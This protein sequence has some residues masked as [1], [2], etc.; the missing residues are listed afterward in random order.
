[1]KDMILATLLEPHQLPETI[2]NLAVGDLRLDSRLI[3]SGDVFICL[4]GDDFIEAAIRAGAHAILCHAQASDTRQA[5]FSITYRGAIPQTVPIIYVPDLAQQLQTLAQLRY[6][7]SCTFPPIVGVTGTNGKSTLV[8][9]VAQLLLAAKSHNQVATIG[10]LGVGVYGEKPFLTGM[11]TP[12]ILTNYKAMASFKETQVSVVTMEVSSHGLDQQRVA[13]LPIKTAIFTNL[14]QD[15]LDY[16]KTLEAYAEA[17]KRLFAMP[18]VTT[19]IINADDP[20]AQTMLTDV[21]HAHVLFY[22]LKNDQKCVNT[23]SVMAENIQAS[24]TGTSFDVVSPW[25]SAT[26]HS[27]FYGEFNVYNCLAAICAAVVE[28][29]DFKR[30]VAAIIHLEPVLGRMQP[31]AMSEQIQVVIDYAHTP[32]ALKQTLLALRAHATGRLWVVFGCGGDRDKR[33]RAQM[34]A[35]AQE[36]ADEIVLTSDN[37]RS[38]DPNSILADIA[39][40]CERE[41]HI[42]ADR[43][44]AI[45]YALGHAQ[46]SD[47][48]L[49]AGK[50]HEQFQIIGNIKKPFSDAD[51]ATRIL[52]SLGR[53]KNMEDNKA[54]VNKKVGAL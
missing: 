18:S 46:V 23:N 30:V 32:D 4:G 31:L 22:G 9:L 38:E 10:T 40:G 5:K 6:G 26:V 1:M 49:I 7:R 37:P 25:G 28:G 36:L 27:P 29:A 33:K 14:S 17:K 21:K 43:K 44:E 54:K 39:K 51:V 53:L 35:V 2:A 12:D 15:H 20:F 50:G 13:G 8:S 19:C 41:A 52:A 34:G 48:V 16:H 3:A 42:I 47:C 11:T 24:P 45:E